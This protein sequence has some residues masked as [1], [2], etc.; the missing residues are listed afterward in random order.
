MHQRR[1]VGGFTLIEVMVVVVI[2]GLMAAVIVPNLFGHEK[3]ARLEKAAID[4]SQI[5][6]A[7]MSFRLKNHR[8]P[9]S[10]EELIAVCMMPSISYS[11]GSSA[12]MSF[13]PI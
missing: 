5:Y 6:G 11:I 9:Y 7:A 13:E 3:R 1:K 4:V 2:I 12:V 10:I 8:W